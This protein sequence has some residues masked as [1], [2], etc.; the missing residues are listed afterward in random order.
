L[1]ANWRH[2]GQ[3]STFQVVLSIA[4]GQTVKL[5]THPTSNLE[6]VAATAFR[7]QAAIAFFKWMM[8]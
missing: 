7:V 5:A 8:K 6:R 3:R 2:F 4:L 1:T